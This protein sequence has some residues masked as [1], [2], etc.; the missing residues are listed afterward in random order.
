MS[1][2]AFITRLGFI[3]NLFNPQS[4]HRRRMRL[5]LLL[6]TTLTATAILFPGPGWSALQFVEAQYGGPVLDGAYGLA[7]SPDDRHLYAAGYYNGIIAVFSRD[8]VT[9][10]LSLTEMQRD[11]VNGVDGLDSVM[12][13]TVSPDGRH[14]YA[15]GDWDDGLAVF[16]RDDT[17]GRLTFVEVQKEGVGGVDGIEGAM[18][19]EVSP[20]N[21][22]VY[23]A[24]SFED[25]VVVFSRNSTTGALTYVTV[26]NDGIDGVEGISGASAIAFSSDSRHLYVTEYFGDTLAVF[27]RDAV[28]GELT[29]LE[30]HEDGVGGIDGLGGAYSV[31]VSPEGT[32]LYVSG[33]FDDAVALFIRDETTGRLTWSQA[34]FDGV[35]G[36][37]G[38]SGASDIA[39]SADG[40]HL[41]VTGYF[42]DT[43]AVFAR[44]SNTGVLSFVEVHQD[45]TAGVD[46]LYGANSVVISTDGDHLY[47]SGE[48]DN[49]VGV[50][51][52]SS[53]T[54]Q[55]NFVEMQQDFYEDTEGLYG[56]VD[57]AASP[58]GE[59]LYTAGYYDDSVS[60][61]TRDSDTGRLTF[62]EALKD[63]TDGVD[64][65]R[66]VS[67]VAVSPDGAHL[68]TV[69]YYDD[70]VAVFNRENVTGQLTFVAV[71]KDGTDGADGLNGARAVAL[72]PDGAHVYIAGYTDDA[73]AVF[74]RN[75]ISGA[76]T[77]RQVLRDNTDGVD[78]LDGVRALV[79][80]PDGNH[81]YA[82]GYRD[83]A[84]AVFSRNPDTGELTFVERQRD[85]LNGVDALNGARAVVV[86]PDNSY[87]YVVGHWDDGVVAFSRDADTGR[88][89]LVEQ[90]RNG[91]NGVQGLNGACALS[92]S[93]DGA[94]LYAAGYYDSAVVAFTRDIATGQLSYEG[95]R[96]DGVDGVD[97]ISAVSALAVTPDGYHLYGTGSYDNAVAVFSADRD[98][99]GI[100]DREEAAG[101]GGG[102]GNSDGLA[103]S[104]QSHVVTLKSFDGAHYVT[105]TA[106]PGTAL[107]NCRATDNPSPA[108][109]PAD[110]AFTYGFFQFTL[111]GLSTGGSAAIGLHLPA[112]ANPQSYYK[113]GPTPDDANDHWYAFSYDN[114][115]GAQIHQNVVTLHFVDGLRGDDVPTADSMVIDIGGPAFANPVSNGSS[116]SGGGGCFISILDWR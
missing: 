106:P 54:G 67:A 107:R 40:D 48:Y 3:N 27:D 58:D 94:Y 71:Y 69:G 63:G 112:G 111:Q 78:G 36:I 104:G 45:D 76:L 24:G 46:G 97:G 75:T 73:V 80:A 2:T 33:E 29:L 50:F 32:H 57:I 25:S 23:V 96:Q 13:V 17:T 102:D 110:V 85:N 72:S 22:H 66:R 56:V 35:G 47:V 108:D 103:D 15:V 20:D 44:Q 31:T 28:S 68:Y 37:E 34:Y 9:G 64:G 115:T 105:L 95:M 87:L 70:A 62:I 49:A 65:L 83:D 74:S 55:L 53:A 60:V 88:L 1:H 82:A 114:E 77:F 41:Y 18:A 89:T 16:S 99:D 93:P 52:R 14:L 86:T 61:F 59:H 11:G 81:L 12:D 109:G 4:L 100:S 43:L 21:R 98:N 6:W 90:Q 116:G 7:A 113:Y 101:P 39:I 19:V 91:E 8:S 92:V 79:V 42:M 10:A 26:Y 30:A 84:V 5:A 38:L 51:A